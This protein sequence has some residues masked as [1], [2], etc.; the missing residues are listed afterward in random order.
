M[1]SN[2]LAIGSARAITVNT[3]SGPIAALGSGADGPVVLLVPGYTGS[4]ED[5]APLLDPLAAQ[6]FQA[7]AIDLPGQYASPGPEDPAAYAPGALADRVLEV[8]EALGARTHLLGH[9][10]GGLVARATVL[11]APRRFVSLVLM[12]SGPAAIDGARR[13]NMEALE[14]VLAAQGM[15]GTYLAMQTAAEAQSGYIAPPPALAEFLRT[16]FLA[17]S[18]A[19]LRGMGNAIRTEPDRV[20][21]LAATGIPTLVIHGAADD[22]WVPAVQAEMAQR[23]HAEYVVVADAAHSPAVENP[24]ATLA[25]LAA[26]WQ[27]HA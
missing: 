25:A 7:V 13:Q 9:S 10:F 8:V 1:S 18:P 4:K 5:F 24:D 2:Q 6:G 20:A 22:A 19:M 12:C 26:F 17:S 3:A 14:P 16:R 15:A 23:L 27:A 11:R 21:E